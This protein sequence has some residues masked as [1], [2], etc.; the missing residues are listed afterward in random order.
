MFRI[1][2][3]SVGISISLVGV[4]IVIVQVFLKQML[5]RNAKILQKE[6]SIFWDHYLYAG[7]MSGIKG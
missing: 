6:D 5:Y 2:W 7:K 1:V 4:S 3:L